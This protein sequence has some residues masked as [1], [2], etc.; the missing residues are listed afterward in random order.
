MPPWCF[1]FSKVRNYYNREH[2]AEPDRGLRGLRFE[3]L[4]SASN[5][6]ALPT[7][8]LQQIDIANRDFDLARGL[9]YGALLPGVAGER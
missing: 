7:Y 4:R 5:V 6:F 8:R 1:R 9:H 2:S 3:I